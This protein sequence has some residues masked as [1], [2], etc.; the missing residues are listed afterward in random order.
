MLEKME[1]SEFTQKTLEEKIITFIEG[2][3]HEVGEVL[4]PMRVSL[5]GRK[6]SPSPFE[7]ADV[8]GKKES[9]KRI[10]TA[11]SLLAKM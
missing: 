3:G 10:H 7:I 9:I 4:W 11:I 2:S 5:C 6:A 8:L 1:E